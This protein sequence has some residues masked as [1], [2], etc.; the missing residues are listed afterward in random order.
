MAKVGDCQKFHLGTLPTEDDKK[1]AGCLLPTS[2]Q[3]TLCLLAYQN[4]GIGSKRYAA[5]KTVDEVVVFYNQARNNLNKD[6]QDE[7]RCVEVVRI[8][9]TTP[10][11]RRERE[12][13]QKKLI[14]F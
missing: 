12:T 1:I 10:N 5:N 6:S 11:E 9:E 3:V 14:N 4:S 7:R 13:F 8:Y 2:R